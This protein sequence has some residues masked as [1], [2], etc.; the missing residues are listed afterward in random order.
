MSARPLLLLTAVAVTL[1]L[2]LS[3]WALTQVDPGAPV[4]IHWNIDG[5]AD[6]F[7]EAWLALSMMPLATA[8][9]GALL[10]FLPRIDPRRANLARSATAYRWIGGAGIVLLAAVHV[11]VVLAAIG[12]ELP[13]DRF[14]GIGAGLVFVVA[15]NFLSK[16]RS[17]WMMGI[18]TPWT[19][20][21]ERSWDRTHR[22]GSYLF[23]VAGLGVMVAAVVA[24]PP[25]IFGVLIGTLVVMVPVLFAYS[26][27]AWRDD[28][29]RRS[30][31]ADR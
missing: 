9:V 11:L 12:R 30:M 24:P 7:A 3:A 6:G 13:V 26:F 21:S 28:P 8:A 22:L 10:A 27:V 2:L 31:E 14:V 4:P 1:Q 5:R 18:R 15:G 16:T 29:E 25:V 20:S 23:I 17:N 19:L